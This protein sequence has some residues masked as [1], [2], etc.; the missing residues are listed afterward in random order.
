MEEN[1]ENK[2]KGQLMAACVAL[3]LLNIGA[4]VM[5]LLLPH[6][7][8]KQEPLVA[9]NEPVH[10]NTIVHH[11]DTVVKHDTVMVGVETPSNDMD[12]VVEQA[13]GNTHGF[14][15]F[16][17]MWNKNG[18]DAVDLDAHASDPLGSEIFYGNK[19]SSSGGHLDVDM[20][21]PSHKGVENI[22]WEKASNTPDGTYRFAINNYDGGN[23]H[24]CDAQIKVGNQTFRYKVPG[25]INGLVQI[26]TVTIRNHQLANIQHSGYRVG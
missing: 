14:M 18:H 21:R 12:Q 10:Y 11:T 3:V 4:F 8:V 2:E 19:S 7:C 13:G 9:K 24:G 26:A 25:K 23:H 17:I 1:N 22:F 15:Q 20:I 6:G 16:S 5:L